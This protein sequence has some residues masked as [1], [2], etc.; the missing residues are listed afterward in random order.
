MIKVK[1]FVFNPFMENTYVLS[2]QSGECIIID[3]GCNTDQERK[4]LENYFQAGIPSTSKNSCNALPCGSCS[5][6]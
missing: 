3:P 4:T 6:M 5:W 1:V 2:D